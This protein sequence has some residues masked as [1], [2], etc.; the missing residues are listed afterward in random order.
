MRPGGLLVFITS[1]STMDKGSEKARAYI[2]ERAD[3]IGAIRLPQTAFKQNAGTDVVTD[4][5]FLQRRMP[6]APA[7]G[8]AWAK[9][10]TVRTVEG[11]EKLVNEYF[12]AHPEMV[13]GRHSS[14]GSMYRGNQYTVLPD[15]ESTIEDQFRKAVEKLPEGVYH[16]DTTSPLVEESALREMDVK[17]NKEG[18]VYLSDTGA[19]MLVEA[20]IR[21]ALALPR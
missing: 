4:V 7:A 19:L 8:E 20:G 2:A 12:V 6:G 13:L 15:T 21:A 1:N 17:G 5:L 3:L 10:D 9:L 16:A 14:S 11:E 18:G